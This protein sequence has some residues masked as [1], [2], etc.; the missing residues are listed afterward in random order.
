MFVIFPLVFVCFFGFIVFAIMSGVRRQAA[1]RATIEQ[2]RSELE[3]QMGWLNAHVTRVDEKTAQRVAETRMSVQSKIAQAVQVSGRGRERDFARAHRIF[4]QA[5]VKLESRRASVERALERAQSMA[6]RRAEAEARRAESEARRAERASRRTGSFGATGRMS[7]CATDWNAIPPTERGVCFFCGRPAYLWE[8]EPVTVP[9]NGFQRRVLA[10]P[11]DRARLRAGQAPLVRAFAVEN[12]YVPWYAYRG[13]DPY[14]DYYALQFDDF[15]VPI[16]LYP[17]D[18]I[19]PQYWDW[20]NSP[21]AAS[22]YAFSPDSEGYRD[23]Y[24]SEAASHADYDDALL[25]DAGLQN[26]G[27]ADFHADLS[28]ESGNFTESQNASDFEGSPV[29]DDFGEDDAADYDES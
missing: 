10:C 6:Q 15:D 23:F 27:S 11:Q 28:G 2:R 20:Q 25:P 14:R 4:D 7:D 5:Q 29:S 1:L 9:L 13:Y 12:H 21:D 8:L 3:S 17:P 16:N 26:V 22:D 19:E 24:S 18:V